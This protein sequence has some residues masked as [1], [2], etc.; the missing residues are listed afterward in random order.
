MIIDGRGWRLI[1]AWYRRYQISRWAG[2]SSLSLISYRDGKYIR[3][4]SK[5]AICAI[6]SS[7]DIS[8]TSRPAERKIGIA[9]IQAS[10]YGSPNARHFYHRQGDSK[11]LPTIEM[12]P[13]HEANQK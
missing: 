8:Q 9:R 5:L 4:M 10:Y 3:D 1:R 7:Y 12:V 11:P 2:K 13:Y 6:V